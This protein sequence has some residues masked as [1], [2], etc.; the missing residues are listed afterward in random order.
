[1][2]VERRAR[3]HLFGKPQKAFLYPGPGCGEALAEELRH[4]IGRLQTPGGPQPTLKLLREAV[5]IGGVDFRSLLEIA[6]RVTT[7][8]DMTLVLADGTVHNRKGLGRL[9]EGVS[10]ELFFAQGDRASLRAESF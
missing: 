8:Q 6:M 1:M 3:T 10:W 9:L 2:N 7:A 5:A 4:L